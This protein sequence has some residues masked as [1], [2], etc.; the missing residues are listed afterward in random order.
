MDFWIPLLG[1]ALGAAIINGVFVF[2][3]L[4]HDKLTEHEIWLR[5]TK[6]QAYTKF[7]SAVTAAVGNAYVADLAYPQNA[8]VAFDEVKLVGPSEVIHTGKKITDQIVEIGRLTS[9]QRSMVPE[10]DANEDALHEIDVEVRKRISELGN[11]TRKFVSLARK[12]MGAETTEAP[13]DRTKS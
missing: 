7:V 2:L 12:D 1:G 10:P 6:Q 9:A 3:K 13:Q 11:L 4:R 8:F 5:G